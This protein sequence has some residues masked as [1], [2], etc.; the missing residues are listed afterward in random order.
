MIA[1]R[2]FALAPL[3]IAQAV[4]G[5]GAIAAFTRLMSPD[6]FGRYAL[7]LSISMFVH[8]LLFTWAEAAAYR[9][10]SA[11]KA[12][13]RLR[14]H[15]ATL[16]VLAALLGGA[17]LMLTAVL[18]F[19]LDVRADIAAISVFAACA[20][21]FRFIT[22]MTRETERAALAIGRYA[23]AE[24]AYL[25]IGFAAGVALLTTL[26]L[27]AAAPF[28]GLMVAGLVVFMIDAP[29]VLARAKGGAP[30]VARIGAYAG[31]GA[32][33]A[34]AIALDLGVQ[35]AARFLIARE[36]GP[37][38]L[39]AYAAA[40][41][42]ARPLDLIFMLAGTA[43][44]PL[45][46]TAYERD[47]ETGAKD[48]ARGA[49]ITMLSLALPACVGLCLTAAPLAQVLIGHGLSTEAARALPW[50]AVAG[51]MSGLNLY[52]W[53]EAFQLVRRTALR[54]AIMLAP[55]AAQLVLTLVLAPRF[56]AAGAAM[57]SACASVFAMILLSVTGRRF[58]ALPVPVHAM[59][60]IAAACAAMAAI[61]AMIPV[62]DPLLTLTLKVAAGAAVYA[63]A[64]CLLDIGGVR[65]IATRIW[66]SASSRLAPAPF[67]EEL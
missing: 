10:F 65:I 46:L 30:S 39:G 21:I 51:L 13:R 44:T 16:L 6:E 18:L 35:T 23:M 8:T 2:L 57:S 41:G 59:A 50:L 19:L 22:R 53:S 20:A 5:F 11:A 31:Y 37:A 54:A 52:Y 64:A 48:A 33:L 14:D 58:L 17:A 38:A 34:L 67:A 45:M 12:E 27:G 15:F 26:H 40:F 56:G 66:P 9:F 42:L 28:A 43:L 24:T 25:A 4:V 63:G 36:A 61:V 1:K 47:G 49:L 29:R 3:Q 32:P 55:G 62:Y 60:R 7:A